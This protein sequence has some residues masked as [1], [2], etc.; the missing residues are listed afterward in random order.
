[1]SVGQNFHPSSF[2]DLLD[3]QNHDNLDQDNLIKIFY[4]RYRNNL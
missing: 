4:L 2:C 1:M 3:Q